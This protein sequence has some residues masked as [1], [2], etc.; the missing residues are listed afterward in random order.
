MKNKIKKL[1]GTLFTTFYHASALKEDI[2]EL[3]IQ[4]FQLEARTV[5]SSPDS[6]PLIKEFREK[7]LIVSL[8]SF[9]Q[10]IQKVD[11]VIYSLLSQSILPD[12]ILLWLSHEEYPNGIDDVPHNI[13]RLQ[14]YGVDILFCANIKSY[15]KLIPALELYPHDIIV[16]ADDDIFYPP[17]WLQSLYT[18]YLENPNY[19]HAHR[20][21]KI[22]FK[23][24]SEL[25]SYWDF[26]FNIDYSETAPSFLNF[27]TGCGGILYPPNSL[28]KD[29]FNKE[30][31]TKLAPYADDIWFWAMAVLQDTKPTL[32]N[33]NISK[34]IDLNV[35]EELPRLTHINKQRNDEQL[36]N[37]F[38]YYPEI[39]E[40]IFEKA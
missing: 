33:K 2:E 19:I 24:A 22:T 38:E 34:L 8:T 28:H 7:K 26:D 3:K 29:V 6:L 23:N 27:P 16:T 14:K 30:L 20:A 39:K 5:L 15:K 13:K 35:F 36:K 9:P 17:H 1:L 4:N 11:I 32:V 40:R 31:F 25:H 12:K 21:H 37:I 10:R 18:S